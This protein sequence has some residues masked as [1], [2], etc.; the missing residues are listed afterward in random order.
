MILKTI[1][2]TCKEIV[3]FLSYQ[4]KSVFKLCVPYNRLEA[5]VPRDS[6]EY[7]VSCNRILMVSIELVYKLQLSYLVSCFKI[8][9]LILLLSLQKQLKILSMQAKS[10]QILFTPGHSQPKISIV[11][12]KVLQTEAK[13]KKIYILFGIVKEKYLKHKIHMWTIHVQQ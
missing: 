9:L 8:K 2:L 11:I 13:A 4:E 1:I 6:I 7:Q 10:F 5:D 3:V 12:T